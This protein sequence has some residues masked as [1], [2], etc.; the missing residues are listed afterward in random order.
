[1]PQLP[2]KRTLA[3]LS[4]QPSALVKISLGLVGVFGVIALLL[5]GRAGEGYG[6]WQSHPLVAPESLRGLGDYLDLL[7]EVLLHSARQFVSPG[8]FPAACAAILWLAILHS[9]NR[10]D[11]VFLILSAVS[12][13][14]GFL[15][16]S[17]TVFC[18]FLQE[19]E[20]NFIFNP[21]ASAVSQLIYFVAGV[22]LREEGLK[23]LCFLPVGLIVAKRRNPL[24]ALLLAGVTGLGFAFH[25]N[26]DYFRS[27]E[28]K[29]SIWARF[30]TAN[31][32]HFSLTG[33]AGFALYRM[34][35]RKGR[36]WEDLLLTFLVVV[37]AHGF[38]DAL[39]LMPKLESYAPLGFLLIAIYAYRYFDPV[40]EHVEVNGLA[41]RISPLGIF[42]VGS[43]ALLCAVLLYFSIRIDFSSAVAGFCLTAGSL[44]PLAFAFI[45]KFRDL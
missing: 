11:R 35:L 9:F 7:R 34:L 41:G 29:A 1:M 28:G 43:A 27:V 45:S 42:V 26:I 8:V 6:A 23:L 3:R 44:I 4:R 40:R 20:R 2:D 32:L 19:I 22:G 31:A 14:L 15:S 13:A 39:L 38:Y 16:A 33:V 12:L 36:G 24:E 21:E 37:A 10:F 18:V 30:L 5:S 17:L 25:E